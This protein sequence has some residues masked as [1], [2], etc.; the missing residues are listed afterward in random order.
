VMS[1]RGDEILELAKTN[2]W[3]WGAHACSGAAGREA[4]APHVAPGVRPGSEP[5]APQRP[6]AAHPSG[7]V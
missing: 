7:I 3:R 2:L 6:A 1:G 5:A 4:A